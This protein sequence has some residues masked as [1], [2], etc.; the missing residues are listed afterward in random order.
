VLGAH[1]GDES[2]PLEWMSALN[3]EQQIA[4]MLKQLR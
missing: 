3:K 2:L 4:Q 1:S